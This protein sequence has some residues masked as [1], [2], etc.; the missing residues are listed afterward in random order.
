M[1]LILIAS[2]FGALGSYLYKTGAVQANEV[3]VG[4]ISVMV[5][6]RILGGVG[7]YLIVMVLFVAAFKNGGSLSVLYPLYAST[8]IFGALIAMAAFGTPI[9]LP[10]LAG[11]GLLIAGMYLMG[12]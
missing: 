11:M 6:P 8:F 10:N 7:S 9:R 2:I 1:I 4:G 3:G 12:R 5:Q